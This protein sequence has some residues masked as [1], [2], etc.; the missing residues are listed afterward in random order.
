MLA[1]LHIFFLCNCFALH[2]RVEARKNLNVGFPTPRIAVV[3]RTPVY[4]S[5]KFQNLQRLLLK[6]L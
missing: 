3:E 4:K 1:C 6:I 2:E 5:M